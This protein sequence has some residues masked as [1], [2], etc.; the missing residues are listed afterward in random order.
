MRYISTRDNYISYDFADILMRGLA[1]DGGLFLPQDWPALSKDEWRSLQGASYSEVAYQIMRRF[2][3]DSITDAE[4]IEILDNTYSTRTNER[5]QD[6]FRHI[7]IA[8]LHHLKDNTYI[9]ELFH[10][11]TLAFK[12]VALQ[13]LGRLFDAQ[14]AKEDKQITII[15]ATSGDTGSAA[16]E[17]CKGCNNVRIFILHPHNRTSDVQRKQMTTVLSDNVFNIALEG[18]FD[19]C[20]NIVKELFADQ[21]LNQKHNFTA[22]NSINW[23]RIMAQIIYYATTALSLGAPD[24][25]V[26]YVVPTGNF[27]N[28]FAAYAAKQLGLPIAKLIIATNEND[29]LEEF[30]RTG[31]MTKSDVHQ[32]LSPSM[33][34]Q[35]SSNFERYLFELFDRD[36][37]KLNEFMSSFKEKGVAS[38]N[39][40]D[41]EVMHQT[42]QAVRVND[43]ETVAT[44]QKTYKDHDY[45]LDP[46]SAVGLS[47]LHKAI[48]EGYLDPELPMISLA[49]AHPA[50]L[51]DAVKKATGVSPSLPEHLSNLF[52]REE[53][54]S[55]LPNSVEA[56]AKFINES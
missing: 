53:R 33:D 36:D 34:I 17:G 5:S 12:D 56:V 51:P 24:K 23:A 16:I 14:L 45:L 43:E 49:C 26:Q 40:F 54:F 19:D 18:T 8:P 27:G 46:H 6:S 50:K 31:Q 25:P 10:G 3:G 32:T 39:Q 42:F 11:P 15:G 37:Q 52:E 35:I 28:I 9:M 21:A 30:T 20:Q 1:P 48:G 7:D 22:I 38:I 4:L 13:F 29:I 2:T 47:A 55:V 44:I 41:L